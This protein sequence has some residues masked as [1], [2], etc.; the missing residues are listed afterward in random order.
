VAISNLSS[1]IPEPLLAEHEVLCE[2]GSRPTPAYVVR[3]AASANDKGL[4]VAQ[5]FSGAAKPGYA[6]GAE[7]IRQAQRIATL[8]SPNLPRVRAVVVSG[9]DAVAFGEFLD[10]EKLAGLWCKSDMQLEV[11]LRV[12]LDVLS[13]V[14]ALQNLRDSQQRPMNLVHGEISPHTIVL[15]LD[16]VA[17]VLD[18][19]A[20]RAPP[21][22][23]AEAASSGYLAPEMLAGKSSDVRADVFSV[24]VLLWEALSGKRLFPQADRPV[25]S[26]IE[27][28]AMLLP[29]ILPAGTAW[30]RGLA[31]IA[32]KALESE[33]EARW[34]S[35][36]TMAAELRKA[37]GLKVAPLATLAAF[38]KNTFA[39]R[40]QARRE[41][42]EGM[43]ALPPA[44]RERQSKGQASTERPF[45]PLLDRQP[46]VALSSDELSIEP[47]E[48]ATI[49][50]AVPPPLPTPA[51]RPTQ[52]VSHFPPPA[53]DALPTFIETSGVDAA[54]QQPA[55]VAENSEAEID[56][57]EEMPRRPGRRVLALLLGVGG[58]GAL[59]FA[60][61]GWRVAY[62]NAPHPVVGIPHAARTPSLADADPPRASAQS[63]PSQAAT[64]PAASPP[65]ASP[66]VATTRTKTTLDPA[67]ALA[68][69]QAPSRAAEVSRG[70]VGHSKPRTMHPFDPNFL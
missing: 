21:G 22:P 28:E 4:L 15:G 63:Q 24:G 18:A 52:E 27:R 36:A 31:A 64:T 26:P 20:R 6:Q 51:F 67:T 25:I 1:G 2:L 49:P 11:A 33:P 47:D 58:F 14:C 66:P 69:I 12:I 30:A 19:I 57:I 16:G 8:T 45:E 32:A 23:H 42:L 48:S 61:A 68:P 50:S 7:F 35:T 54:P 65:R 29:A 46:A 5:C 62:Q 60:L 38:A 3:R 70:A 10:G 39:D 34:S 53:A 44:S 59:V 43:C 37:V 56:A 41:R 9:D 13:G 40:V 55:V 17:R